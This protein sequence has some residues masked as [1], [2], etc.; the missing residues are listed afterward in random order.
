MS[1]PAECSTYTHNDNHL[2]DLNMNRL[3]LWAAVGLI[4]TMPLLTG[5][6]HEAAQAHTEHPATVEHI[7]GSEISKVTL[8]E[9]AMKRLDVQ[10]GKVSEQKS[11]RTEKTQKTVPY[12]ALIYDTT[13]ATWIFTSPEDRVFVRAQVDVDFIDGDTAYLNGGPET[14]TNVAT[15]GVAELYGT[16]FAVGH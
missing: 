1:M 8:M 3:N 15:V 14:G 10:T 9:P 13:G 12:S 7:E 2:E 11:P 6:Q 4:A 5:C 16:E